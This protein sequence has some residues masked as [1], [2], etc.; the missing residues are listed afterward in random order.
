MCSHFEGLV[1][2]NYYYFTSIPTTNQE[3][4]L[5][6]DLFH[7]RKLRLRRMKGLHKISH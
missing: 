1:Y 2:H 3:V 7:M 4:D 5:I 6:I